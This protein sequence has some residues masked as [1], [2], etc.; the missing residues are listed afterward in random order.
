MCSE[1]VRVLGVCECETAPTQLQRGHGDKGLC[2][3]FGHAVSPLQPQSGVTSYTHTYT[4][5]HTQAQP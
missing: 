1:S 4:G 3:H 5:T 2:V